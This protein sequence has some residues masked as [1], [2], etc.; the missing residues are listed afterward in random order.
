MYKVGINLRTELCKRVQFHSSALFI[1]DTE[2]NPAAGHLMI[3][4]WGGPPAAK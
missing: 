1:A 3:V 4:S 2:A